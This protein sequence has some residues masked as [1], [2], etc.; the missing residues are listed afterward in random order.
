MNVL[1][2]WEVLVLLVGPDFNNGSLHQRLVSPGC[3]L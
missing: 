2:E 1:K 3:S